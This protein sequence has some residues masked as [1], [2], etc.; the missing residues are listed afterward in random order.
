MRLTGAGFGILLAVWSA[1]AVEVGAKEPP[2]SIR[3]VDQAGRSIEGAEVGLGVAWGDVNFRQTGWEYDL[4]PVKTDRE[5]L[6]RLEVETRLLK[7]LSITARQREK[8]LIAVES[9]DPASVGRLNTLTMRPECR[10]AGRLRCRV[11]DD[12]GSSLRGIC[13]NLRLGKQLAAEYWSL[14]PKFEFILPAGKYS[15]ELR[16]EISGTRS[17]VH[18]LVVPDGVERLDLDT[19]ELHLA[20]YSRLKGRKAPELR[21]VA[22][23]KNGSAIRLAD[24]RGKVV[25]L[26]F[27]GWWCG[28]CVRSMP[29]LFELH[30]KYHDKGLVI[31]GIHVEYDGENGVITAEGL[32]RKLKGV[33]EALW[34]GRD[35]PF[36]VALTRP[37]PRNLSDEVNRSGL[38][39]VAADYG[40]ENYPTTILIDRRSRIVGRIDRD[41]RVE[42]IEAALSDR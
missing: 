20:E 11:L 36:S 16:S 23:W 26:D 24:L 28:A 34:G 27:W 19:I 3:L 35:L 39:A 14:E 18:P 37:T 2:I 17:A 12:R 1:T 13:A 9:L 42:L 8:R 40:V 31:I 4:G 29:G 7:G 32:D 15:L 33:R 5:G 21:E 30:D 38:C 25:L 22:A 41:N 10:V 6:A